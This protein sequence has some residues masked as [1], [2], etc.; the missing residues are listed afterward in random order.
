MFVLKPRKHTLDTF[1]YDGFERSATAAELLD[2]A[3]ILR[4]GRSPLKWG[5][6]A[7]R[8]WR[9]SMVFNMECEV[10]LELNPPLFEQAAQ[11]HSRFTK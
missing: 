4:R 5:T 6:L 8:N 10:V 7:R 2:V 1:G 11:Q 3:E 9:P